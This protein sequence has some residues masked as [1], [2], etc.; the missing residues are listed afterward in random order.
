MA[1]MQY[2]NCIKPFCLAVSLREVLIGA[3]SLHSEHCTNSHKKFRYILRTVFGQYLGLNTIIQCPVF[4]DSMA[5]YRAVD[6]A[7]FLKF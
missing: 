2:C 6:V 1:E 3:G 7:C 4:E 5:I